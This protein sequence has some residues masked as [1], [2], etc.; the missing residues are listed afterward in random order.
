LNLKIAEQITAEPDPDNQVALSG[1]TVTAHVTFQDAEI[2]ELLSQVPEGR[3]ADFFIRGARSG[4]IAMGND[5]TGRLRE[6]MRFMQST[7]DMQVGMFSQRMAEKIREQLGDADADG[8]VEHRLQQILD[9]TKTQLKA[10]MEKALPDVFDQQTKRS[11]EFIQAEGERVMRQIAALFAENGLAFNVIQDARR[12]FSQRI[13]EMKVAM[14]VAQTRAAN[15]TPRDAGLDYEAWVHGQLASIATLRGDEVEF[16]GK[17]AGHI[18]RCM[19]GDTRMTLA[20]EGVDV[21]APPCIAVEIR[22]REGSEFTIKEVEM[23]MTNRGAHVGVLVA[24]H[25]GSLPKQCSDRAFVV[26]RRKRMVCV[27]VGPDSAEAAAL[28]T[29]AYDVASALAIEAVRRTR[30]GDWDEVA[31]R[32]EAIEEAVGG[33]AAARAAFDSIEK[34]AHDAGSAASRY[35]ALLVRLVSDLAAVVKA[36]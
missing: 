21:T 3:R 15:P 18:T 36:Q 12:D 33:A 4:L 19:K 28:L 35:H 6:A 11:S 24:A 16:T 22:D 34:K 23:M 27:V 26:Q 2:S 31:R 7:L 17:T 9:G 20:A 29:A 10:E 13:E 1:I 8:H 14:T 5:V 30:N 25:P 32:V